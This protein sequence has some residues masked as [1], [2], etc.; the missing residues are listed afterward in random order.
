MEKNVVDRSKLLNLSTSERIGLI[1]N[2]KI[3][4][5]ALKAVTE[6]IMRCHRSYHISGES[7]NMFISGETGVGKTTLCMMYAQKH[8]VC[9]K[10]E[11]VKVPVL[12]ARTRTPATIKWLCS[13]LLD[14]LG[15]PCSDKGTTL[16]ITK[17]LIKLTRACGVELILLDEFQHISSRATEIRL[18][19]T[20]DWLKVFMEDTNI[21]VVLIGLPESDEILKANSQLGRRFSHRFRLL[22][23]KWK[24][25][26]KKHFRNLIYTYDAQLPLPEQS[27]LAMG[28]MPARIFAASDGVIGYA[29]I[30]LRFAAQYA[31]EENRP[32]IDLSILS[33]SFEKHIKPEK[34]TKAN[35]FIPERFFLE[36]QSGKY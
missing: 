2:I 28:D 35:P 30:L 26:D 5:P 33:K 3:I 29:I 4:H 25:D 21:P 17:R 15:D 14:Q 9:E 19:K 10:K 31:V 20:A 12:Y 1:K 16:S 8:P 23:F 18:Y 6:D 27:D 7:E 22:P 11:D 32:K 34:P 36:N 13:N 24:D